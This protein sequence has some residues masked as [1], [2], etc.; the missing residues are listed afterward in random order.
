MIPPLLIKLR[1]QWFRIW[2]PLFLLNPLLLVFFLI[3]AVVMLPINL[4]RGRPRESFKSTS[5]APAVYTL[6]CAF[7]GLR[8]DVEDGK[9]HTFEVVVW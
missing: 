1:I 5:L 8:I 9:G 7:R 4:L 3:A 2:L 6:I